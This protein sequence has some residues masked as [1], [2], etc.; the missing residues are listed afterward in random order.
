MGWLKQDDR[1]L[2]L[3][4]STFA[5]ADR[6]EYA[7]MQDEEREVCVGMSPLSINAKDI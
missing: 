1:C 3:L 6:A 7:R 2:L 4:Q 5:E